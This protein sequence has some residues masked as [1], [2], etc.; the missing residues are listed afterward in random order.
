MRDEVVLTSEQIQ[1]INRRLGRQLTARLKSEEK[2]PVVIAVMIR[3]RRG[4]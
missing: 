1:T 3:K 4:G 2:I